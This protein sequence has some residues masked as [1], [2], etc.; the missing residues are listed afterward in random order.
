MQKIQ[1]LIGNMAS[2]PP[3]NLFA[4]VPTDDDERWR[5][6]NQH[7]HS[8]FW[9]V[10]IKAFYLYGILLSIFRST[11]ILIENSRVPILERTF[12]GNFPRYFTSFGICSSAIELFGRCIGGVIEPEGQSGRCLTIG[13]NWLARPGTIEVNNRNLNIVTTQ[14]SAYTSQDLINLRNFVAH[15]QATTP[16]SQPFLDFDLL[17]PFPEMMGRA[18]E[19][20]WF[21]VSTRNRDLCVNLAR[22][23][24]M[25]VHLGQPITKTLF[26]FSTE[27]A[28]T[29]FFR[30]NFS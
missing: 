2:E 27:A 14:R 17:A 30:L 7:G 13:F 1:S 21:E 15:G 9:P 10:T 8:G 22:A 3:V 23:N 11:E 25:A 12:Q 24:L 29:H 18:V 20:W 26:N 6:L 28:G 5:N 19:T 4:N 16:R